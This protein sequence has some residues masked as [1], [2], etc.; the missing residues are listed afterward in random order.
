MTNVAE[1]EKKPESEEEETRDKESEK[2]NRGTERQDAITGNLE[3]T[4]RGEYNL[5]VSPANVADIE[6]I[7]GNVLKSEAEQDQK[8]MDAVHK[9]I[10]KTDGFTKSDEEATED[11]EAAEQPNDQIVVEDNH[12]VR[13]LFLNLVNQMDVWPRASQKKIRKLTDSGSKYVATEFITS[14]N[15]SEQNSIA[16]NVPDHWANE[17]DCYVVSDATAQEIIETFDGI[18]DKARYG[19]QLAGEKEDVMILN[20]NGIKTAFIIDGGHLHENKEEISELP[21]I[22]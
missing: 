13:D 17:Q 15:S 10:N 6:Q 11:I 14:F 2:P 12:R 20:L 19:Y 8:W 1:F 16:D 5:K 21:P 9:K 22:A 4:F 3:I 7:L 18:N